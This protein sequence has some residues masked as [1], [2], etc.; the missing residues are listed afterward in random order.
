MFDFVAEALLRNSNASVE[1]LAHEDIRRLLAR[2]AA[3]KNPPISL[4]PH[5]VT[6]LADYINGYPPSAYY[7][8]SL[9]SDYGIAAVLADKNRLVDFRTG[10]FIRFLRQRKFT[11]ADRAILSVLARYSPIPLEALHP[12]VKLDERVVAQRL[13]TLIDHS[14]VVVGQSSL[15]SIAEPIADAVLRNFWIP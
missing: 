3:S 12:V 11:D 13:M 14:L 8:I 9:V 10:V 2:I 4:E 15:Y 6:E 5:Q 7:A 1:S